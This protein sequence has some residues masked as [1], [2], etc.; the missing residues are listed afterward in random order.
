MAVAVRLQQAS[1]SGCSETHHP[2]RSTKPLPGRP[3]TRDIAPAAINACCSKHVRRTDAKESLASASRAA[4]QAD[5]S[6]E[7][8]IT[9]EH[10]II[11]STQ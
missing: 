6:F 3:A 4:L 7:Y 8:W 1:A 2:W 10:T 5:C 11:T 9:V